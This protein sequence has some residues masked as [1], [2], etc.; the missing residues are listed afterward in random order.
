MSPRIKPCSS[1]KGSL[2]AARVAEE[3]AEAARPSKRPRPHPPAR[4]PPAQAI[5]SAVAK[6]AETGVA[7]PSGPSTMEKV[8]EVEVP[9][10]AEEVADEPTDR[11]LRFVLLTLWHS[12]LAA[13][14]SRATVFLFKRPLPLWQCDVAR[15]FAIFG[16]G[17]AAIDVSPC[18][19][20]SGSRQ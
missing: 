2:P 6:A 20:C 4:P 14:L 19:C 1:L 9:P 17:C 15:S 12:G 13:V 16:R 5:R 8:E 18:L 10:P 7:G 11:S 3:G